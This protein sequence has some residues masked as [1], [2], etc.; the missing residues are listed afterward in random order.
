MSPED[1]Y[2]WLNNRLDFLEVQIAAKERE[3]QILQDEYNKH[4]ERMR[5]VFGIVKGG[6]PLSTAP[7]LSAGY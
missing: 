7:V 4:A 5:D 6:D 2:R 3:K 1:E